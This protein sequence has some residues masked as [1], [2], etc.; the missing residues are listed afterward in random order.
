MSR[1]LNIRNAGLAL[2]AGA[3]V[4][5]VY[6]GV[7]R[8]LPLLLLAACPLSMLF[9]HGRGGHHG[10]A[11]TASSQEFGEYVCPMHD[12]VRSTFPGRCP[13]CGMNLRRTT[14]ASSAARRPGTTAGYRN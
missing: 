4:L 13:V 8:Y 2:V 1:F 10:H 7:I 5:V 11:G 6:P 12:H 14:N 3:A 9:M